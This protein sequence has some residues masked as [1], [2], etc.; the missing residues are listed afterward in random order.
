MMRYFCALLFFL[1]VCTLFANEPPF[2]IPL[3]KQNMGR[4]V[5]YSS[6]YTTFGGVVVPYNSS[7]GALLLDLRGHHFDRGGYAANAGVAFRL[8]HPSLGFNAFYDFRWSHH[9]PFHQVGAGL[10]F[11]KKK[12]RLSL[13]GYLP[14]GLKR[15]LISQDL[16]NEYKGGYFIERKKYES[17]L[18]GIDLFAAARLC[19]I[20]SWALFLMSG[21]YYYKGPWRS[22]V[23]GRLFL[24]SN[25]KEILHLSLGAT[26]DT[27]FK[28]RLQGEIALR[29]PLG[30]RPK[31]NVRMPLLRS[32]IIALDRTSHWRWNY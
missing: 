30:K 16:F 13:N 4:G 27:V 12:W 19:K 3:A 21:P 28:T 2:F 11:L 31:R 23:G 6:G 10:E 20:S 9:F 24:S 8:P 17:S 22:V 25:W 18:G 7:S 5:G 26:S 32:E 29:Y 14:F 15:R 1:A